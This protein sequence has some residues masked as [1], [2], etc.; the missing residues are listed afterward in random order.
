MPCCAR[1]F[2]PCTIGFRC[3]A[4]GVACS[5]DEVNVPGAQHLNVDELRRMYGKTPEATRKSADEFLKGFKLPAD[6]SD[7]TNA[8]VFDAQFK[9]VSGVG[10]VPSSR[11]SSGSAGGGKGKSTGGGGGR[12]K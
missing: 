7:A 5:G 12:R 6:L 2:V 1:P 3:V 10:K 8:N 9:D 11:G 4:C